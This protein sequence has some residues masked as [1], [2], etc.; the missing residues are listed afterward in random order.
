MERAGGW[1]EGGGLGSPGGTVEIVEKARKYTPLLACRLAFF[2]FLRLEGKC[3]SFTLQV[4][5]FFFGLPCS[6]WDSTQK[7]SLPNHFAPP[8]LRRLTVPQRLCGL[9]CVSDPRSPQSEAKARQGLTKF[10]LICCIV[11]WPRPTGPPPPPEPGVGL[12]WSGPGEL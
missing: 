2:S 5:F 12:L 3:V 6:E 10:V 8:Q 7:P 9:V 11:R 1:E 4:S